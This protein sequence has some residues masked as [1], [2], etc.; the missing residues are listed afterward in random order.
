MAKSKLIT[1]TVQTPVGAFTRTVTPRSTRVSH[2]VVRGPVKASV[3]IANLER[4]LA[5]DV[6]SARMCRDAIATQGA[7]LSPKS[8]LRAHL[9]SGAVA[10]W[11]AE[12]EASAARVRALLAAGVQDDTDV[13]GVAGYRA[14]T[15][16][17]L[18]LRD[19]EVASGLYLWVKVYDVTTGAEV[20]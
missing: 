1:Y 20:L 14:S 9:A 16:A 5:A 6:A 17:A 4:A 7:S 18:R 15:A 12:Y 3:K 11:A 10:K 2:V 13:Y 19:F 8:G